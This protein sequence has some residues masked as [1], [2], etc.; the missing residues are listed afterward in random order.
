MSNVLRKL[1]FWR[2][3]EQDKFVVQ[4]TP[5]SGILRDFI[6][7]DVPLVSTYLE[8]LTGGVPQE[9]SVSREYR[10]SGEAGLSM[11][12]FHIDLQ[13]GGSRG[14]QENQTIYWD[15]YAR[16]EKELRNAGKLIDFVGTEPSTAALKPNAIFLISGHAL[17]EPDWSTWQSGI[18]LAKLIIDKLRQ[19]SALEA[20]QQEQPD[21]NGMVPMLYE[22]DGKAVIMVRKDALSQLLPDS[23]PNK[24]PDNIRSLFKPSGVKIV[25]HVGVPHEEVLLEGN[26]SLQHFTPHRVGTYLLGPVEDDIHVLGLV[27]QRN[28][29][30]VQFIPLAVFVR[31]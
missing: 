8:Q 22:P 14:Y 15:R 6:Y 16:L 12:L 26:A 18:S 5:R 2:Q 21:A 7:L 23:L 31:I 11:S 10:G 28:E 27:R 20:A 1:A 17:L 25:L 3:H 4:A 13:G 19:L 29:A 30:V 9:A 24:P